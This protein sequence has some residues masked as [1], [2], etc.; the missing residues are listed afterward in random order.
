[1]NSIKYHNYE[2]YED[3]RIYSYFV[4]RF[5]KPEVD[6]SGYLQVKLYVN[7]KVIRIKVH[8]LVA[9]LFI[10]NENMENL[11]INH[12]DGDKSNNHWSNL[13][14]CTAYENNKHAI[15]MGLNNISKTNSER[16]NDPEFRERTSKNISKGKI[17]K[18]SAAHRKNPRFRYII[19]DK[20]GKEYTRS[21]LAE[22]LNY[23]Q[24]TTATWIRKTANG[25]K[26]EN[27]IAKKYEITVTDIKKD[28]S[29]IESK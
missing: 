19:R 9:M 22:L 12:I 26:L 14:W 8:R 27:P 28:V 17:N 11:Q 23:A 25:E 18:G 29:T 24:S 21:E 13:E 7:N 4:N 10:P 6:K 20:Y 16:W 2:I 1:M 15:D 5:L 3:G